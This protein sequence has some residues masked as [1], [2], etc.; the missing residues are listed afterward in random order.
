MIIFL[1]LTAIFRHCPGNLSSSWISSQF[2]TTPL[3]KLVWEFNLNSLK[4]ENLRIPLLRVHSYIYIQY[5]TGSHWGGHRH[6]QRWAC[7]AEERKSASF[8]LVSPQRKLRFS[9]VHLRSL[10]FKLLGTTLNRNFFDWIWHS[11][12]QL[13]GSYSVVVKSS[14]W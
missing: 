11:R 9:K 4:S 1:I 14:S 5:G 2:N 7:C 8:V 12:F 3:K 10:P 6:F 13:L